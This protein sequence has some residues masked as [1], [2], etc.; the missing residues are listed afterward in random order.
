L[1]QFLVTVNTIKKVSACRGK[2]ENNY[3]E[4]SQRC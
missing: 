3:L 1:P 2:Q 4:A